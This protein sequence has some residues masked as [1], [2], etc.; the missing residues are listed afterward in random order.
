MT[1]VMSPREDGVPGRRRD[2][3]CLGGL[4][5]VARKPCAIDL[6]SQAEQPQNEE[7]ELH[8]S[9]AHTLT[10]AERRA[11]HAI[12]SGLDRRKRIE[13]NETT[14]VV[15]VPVDRNVVRAHR[16]ESRVAP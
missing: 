9:V 7:E 12:D 14:V 6:R 1:S 13:P 5:A 16:G 11:V 10:D 4:G 8:R 2:V 15:T 3:Q